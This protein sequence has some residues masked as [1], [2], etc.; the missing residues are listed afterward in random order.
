VKAKIQSRP[1][2]E[3]EAHMTS[4]TPDMQAVLERLEKLERQNRRLKQRGVLVILALGAL[5]VMGQAPRSRIVKA[6]QFVLQDS[7]GRARVTIGTPASSGGAF[8][9][10]PDEPAI[11]ITDETGQDRAILTSDGL[12]FANEK[13]K[14]LATYSARALSFYGTKGKEEASLGEDTHGPSLTLMGKEGVTFL[15]ITP[16]SLEIWHNDKVRAQLEA[17]SP[18][19]SEGP[20]LIVRDAT[21]FESILGVAGLETPDTGESHT[22]SAAS[23][24]MLGKDGKV[25]WR[26]P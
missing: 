18:D 19:N 15:G 3:W 12:R 23:L 2:A 9:L 10:S 1:L 6:E 13:G 21:G 7:Q 22:T 5:V 17:G 26:A 16:E 14:P 4:P 11:W 25:I 20:H 24:V 8:H